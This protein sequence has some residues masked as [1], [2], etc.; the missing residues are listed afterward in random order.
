MHTLHGHYIGGAEIPVDFRDHQQMTIGE[1]AP[2]LGGVGRFTY[3]VKLVMQMLG[4]LG[5]HFA[6]LQA[7]AV[8]RE[9]FNQ[10]GKGI[11]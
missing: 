10:L 9:A 2:Q 1:V 3:Q 5:H 11:E 6:G 4:K 8:F 7:T